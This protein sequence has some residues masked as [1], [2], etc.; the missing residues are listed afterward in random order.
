MT[1]NLNMDFDKRIAADT[2]SQPWVGTRSNGV[3]RKM[4]EREET[5]SGRATTIVRFAPDSSFSPHVHD[6][7][8]EFYVLD[9]VFSDQDGDFGPGSYIRNPPGSSHQPQSREGTTIFVKLGHMDPDDQETVRIDTTRQT[10]LPGLV[11]G[12]SVMPLHQFGTSNTALVKWQPGTVFNAHSHPGGEEI[13]V[14][15]GTFEDEHGTYS[16]GT[17]L[18]S[19]P[20]SIHKPF[21]TEGCIILVKTGHLAP[22]NNVH[23]YGR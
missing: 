15:E 9:G 21:S 19:P 5:E 11:D 16:Q 17:W 2:N 3:E 22:T 10:W 6:G 14:L 20:G 23:L 18:R 8:E 12:L 7:G 1:S 4:L 13:L